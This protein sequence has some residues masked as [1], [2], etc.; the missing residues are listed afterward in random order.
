V[1]V[2]IYIYATLC[3]IQICYVVGTCVLYIDYNNINMSKFLYVKDTLLIAIA[4]IRWRHI[5]SLFQIYNFAVSL[6]VIIIIT[7]TNC[8]IVKLK[9]RHS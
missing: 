4:Q 2:I 5:Y 7:Y 3:L 6:I 8:K 9:Q 1:I